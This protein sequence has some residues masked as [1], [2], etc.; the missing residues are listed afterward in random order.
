MIWVVFLINGEFLRIATSSLMLSSRL[1][2]SLAGSS[3]KYSS[4]REN[5]LENLSELH[6]LNV[7]LLLGS[8][9]DERLLDITVMEM[10]HS[11]V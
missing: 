7:G 5:L 11:A 3:K 8:D 10:D 4:A 2:W 6:R 9:F 1:Q